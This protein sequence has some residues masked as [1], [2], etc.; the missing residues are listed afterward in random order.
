MRSHIGIPKCLLNYFAENDSVNVYSLSNKREYKQKANKA[1]TENNYYDEEVE[2]ILSCRIE[3]RLG[4]LLKD[5][6]NAS[7]IEEKIRIINNNVETLNDFVVFQFQR[8]KIALKD[9]NENSVFAVFGSLDHSTY[10]RLLS[11]LDSH[12]ISLLTLLK[13]PMLATLAVNNDAECF[14]TNSIGLYFTTLNKRMNRIVI[15]INSHEAIIIEDGNVDDS[16][17]PFY[18][19]D[20]K[21]VSALNRFCYFFEKFLGNG[22]LYKQLP[23]GDDIIKFS[24]R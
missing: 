6:G 16:K 21:D 1:G 10:I 3:T 23:F 11:Q 15:P 13:Q 5:L 12:K 24:Q 19:L 2:Q 14:I 17:V 8:A 9:Y 18:E 7:S 22:Y 20:G 4:A